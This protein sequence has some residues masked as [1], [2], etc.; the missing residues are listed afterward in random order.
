MWGLAAPRTRGETVGLRQGQAMRFSKRRWRAGLV[1][2]QLTICAALLGGPCGKDGPTAPRGTAVD[3]V[4]L[5][6]T[7][8]N[9]R[10]GEV[11]HV[12]ATPITRT[13]LTVP[14]VACVFA[15]NPS[16]IA[17]VNAAT[18]AVTA[19]SPGL[20]TITA[21]CGPR[22]ASV[23]LTVR[24]ALVFLTI[25]TLGN[26]TGS[27]FASP[28][29]ALGYEAGTTVTLTAR[30]LTVPPNASL[31]TGW[32]GACALA[33]TNMTCV[34]V[35]N[36]NLAVTATFTRGFALTLRTAGTGSG[37]ITALPTG[38]VFAAGTPV[39]LTA[40][41]HDSSAFAGWADDCAGNAPNCG[42]VMNADRVVTAH[43]ARVVVLS[44]DYWGDFGQF[45]S[46]DGCTFDGSV[47]GSL[48][49]RPFVRSDGTMGG[50]VTARVNIGITALVAGCTANPSSFSQA[51]DIQGTPAAL[52]WEHTGVQ[53]FSMRFNGTL[54]TNRIDGNAV[55][56]RTFQGSGPSGTRLTV[57]NARMD[58]M[59][60]TP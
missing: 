28:T 36:G 42:V 35:M 14:N 49:A 6:V 57:L 8:L 11:V 54:G 20:V 50:T 22:A 59:Y 10:V 29:G 31:F 26:G 13:G 19:V 25:A 3:S 4:K 55:A 45:S 60:L 58:G 47:S 38:T 33:V 23:V 17:T 18:G 41:A 48:T 53:A 46:Y 51:V 52:T 9:P 34:L 21:T 44:T 12:G 43:F 16:G 5:T 2:A 56:T 39:A 24:P 1:A 15:S 7:S 32:G 27:V 37:G 40:I 30:P